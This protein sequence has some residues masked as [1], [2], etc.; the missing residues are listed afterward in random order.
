[1]LILNTCL[2]KINKILILLNA[3]DYPQRRRGLPSAGE[4]LSC[5]PR[6]RICAAPETLCDS[7][8][9]AS[10]HRV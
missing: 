8:E 2:L 3:S 5:S 1:M 6:A 7:T 10:E 9:D 4:P